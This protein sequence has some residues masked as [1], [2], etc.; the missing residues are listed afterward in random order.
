VS[1]ELQPILPRK[2]PDAQ[3][4]ADIDQA[5]GRNLSKF[6]LPRVLT[7]RPGYEM[8][9][10]KLTRNPAIVVTVRKKVAS[11]PPGQALPADVEGFPVDVRQAGTLE[12]LRADDPARYAALAAT[13]R[14]EASLASFPY[15]R[16]VETGAPV[17]A[18]FGADALAARAPKKQQVKYTPPANA[19]LD[20]IT[21]PMAI[22][23]NA[24]PDAGWVTLRDFLSRVEGDLTIG[25]YDFTSAHVLDELI[26]AMRNAA[27][28]LVLTLDHPK[29]NP[30]ADQTDEEAVAG[31]EK[32]LRAKLKQA[33]ALEKQDPKVNVWI[34]PSAYH[35]KVAV[36]GDRTWLSSGNWNNSNQPEIDLDKDSPEQIAKAAK[37]RDR[38]WH[39]VVENEQFAGTYRAF[40]QNDYDVAAENAAAEA[41]AAF[42]TFFERGSLTDEEE[43][44]LVAETSVHARAPR[45]Y[46]HAMR[47]P[48]EGT[49]SMTLQPLLTPDEHSY[50]EH[51]LALMRS[52]Q[53]TFYMQTQY[54]HPPNDGIDADFAELI[55]EV[56]A[57]QQ[58]GVDVRIVL[59]QWQ[60]QNDK[61]GSPHWWERL[62]QT[63]MDLTAVKI[64][65]GVHNKGIVVD[66]K[67]VMLGSQN[68][69]GDGVLRNRDASVIVFD[70]EAAQYYEKIFL[71]DWE[72]MAQDGPLDYSSQPAAA[73]ARAPSFA[74]GTFAA[75]PA[76][77]LKRTAERPGQTPIDQAPIPEGYRVALKRLGILTTENLTSV[78]RSAAPSLSRYLGTDIGPIV[79][80]IR[81]AMPPQ[82]FA[83]AMLPLQPSLGVPLEA[84]VTAVLPVIDLHSG[85]FVPQ[86]FL[87]GGRPAPGPKPSVNLIADMQPIRDQGQRGT[88][89]AHACVA[90]MEHF[91]RT[92]RRQTLA[93]SEQ[94]LFYR[95]KQADGVPNAD[96]TFVRVAMPL[97]FAAGDCLRRTW[98]YNPNP[99]GSL[100]QGPPPAGA[101]Q[102]ASQYK[103]VAPNALP[104]KSVAAI[105]AELARG[106]CVAISVPFYDYAWL[107]D[108]IRRTGDIVLPIPGD[109][110]SEGHA[111]CL[112][113]YEDLDEPDL[114]GGRFL[115]R[116]S[117]DAQWGMRCTYGTGYGTIPYAYV[118]TYGREAYSIG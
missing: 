71:H 32:A 117:W 29:N 14:P 49:R 30:N 20:A 51:V 58:R 59:S 89:V 56:I 84:P 76:L 87:R 95:C 62:Q 11:V 39:L 52:A 17:S 78:A 16:F 105:K 118:S 55:D 2:N 53:K 57:L 80:Q 86:T 46:F 106:R 93:F 6:Q 98:A 12:L 24:S 108:E 4:F 13:G 54:I 40:L 96:G 113:G 47:I 109:V 116:N 90:A 75:A 9:G 103:I 28:N 7:V 72:Y 66:S 114:G 22:T 73:T 43:S 42:A 38:D 35:I 112:V 85:A 100:G 21:A 15:E 8:I 61:N 110:T 91:W 92:Q 19:T 36:S 101:D 45:Q 27:G 34:Y 67:T 79:D 94:Y 23:C 48:A 37:S 83:A 50:R 10:G 41:P 33:W 60:V 99:A 63:G 3:T 5:I 65:H 74:M 77:E 82:T 104:P 81:S 102:E 25:M 107:A 115:V 69:S 18:T 111:I 31:L 70:E 26:D 97:L 88:C 68:W 1:P 64:Q 44:S